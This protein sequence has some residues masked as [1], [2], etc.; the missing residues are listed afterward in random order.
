MKVYNGI[1]EFAKKG[2]AIVTSGTFDGVHIGHQ[3][4]L[5]TLQEIAR[6]NGGETVLITFWP[7]PRLVLDPVDDKIKLLTLFEEKARVLERYG[8]DHLVKINFTK[9]F[10]E[11]TS[12]E[13][14][15]QIL[16]DGLGTKTL[17]IGY[18]HKFGKNRE[19]SF[20]A[21]K[22]NS[23]KWGFTVK[24]IPRQDIENVGVSSSRIRKALADGDIHISN[25]YLGYEYCLNGTVVSGDKLGRQLGY[26]TANLHIDSPLKLIPAGG[27]YAVR[28]LHDENNYQGMLNIGTRPTVDGSKQTIEVHIFDFDKEIYGD[29]LRVQLVKRIRFEQKFD[30]L[31]LLKSQL[32]C[33]KEMARKILS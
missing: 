16:V 31:D 33:D 8:L 4:I 13:F 6:D 7:H 26:P 30:S 20:A 25:Q 18:D 14:I 15:K 29:A 5:R 12:A 10:S 2:N 1:E 23:E 17:V 32:A 22:A 3:K 11:L 24:E 28:V 21:L 27:S 9:E 19:G